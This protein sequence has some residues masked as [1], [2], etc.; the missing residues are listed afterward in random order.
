MKDLVVKCGQ[1]LIWDIKYGGEP[2][3]EVKWLLNEKE[4][5]VDERFFNSLEKISST[6]SHFQLNI[7]GCRL[8]S[9]IKIQS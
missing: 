1:S 8:I 6:K 4:V 5:V 3:P 2:D 9:M 7:L